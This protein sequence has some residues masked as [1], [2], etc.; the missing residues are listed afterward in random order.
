[1]S[2]SKVLFRQTDKQ[3][4]RRVDKTGI[5]R[6]EIAFAKK[7]ERERKHFGYRKRKKT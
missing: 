5:E 7:T 2:L 1:M 3:T 4:E 6:L